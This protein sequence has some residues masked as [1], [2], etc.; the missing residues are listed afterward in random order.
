[1]VF[2]HSRNDTLKTAR[3]MCELAKNKGEITVFHCPHSSAYGE[4]RKNVCNSSLDGK[5]NRNYCRIS[6]KFKCFLLFY[7][8]MIKYYT[9][10]YFIY[11]LIF[12]IN[13]F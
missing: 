3:V 2:V 12:C 4:A 5:F 13:L 8:S 1:M 6:N 10:L 9:I 7:S 11:S